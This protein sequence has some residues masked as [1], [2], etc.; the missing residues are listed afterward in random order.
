MVCADYASEVLGKRT[1]PV[2]GNPVAYRRNLKGVGT[3]EKTLVGKPLG[4]PT[5][6]AKSPYC[7]L[8]VASSPTFASWGEDD[9]DDQVAFASEEAMSALID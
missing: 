2:E 8:R 3:V 5:T 6:D 7:P 4:V 1:E 9:P